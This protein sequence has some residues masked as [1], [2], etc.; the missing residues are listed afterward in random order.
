MLTE[1]YGEKPQVYE[2]RPNDTKYVW[3]IIGLFVILLVLIILLFL[4]M[5]S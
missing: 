4:S 2:K 3:I 5:N 1:K